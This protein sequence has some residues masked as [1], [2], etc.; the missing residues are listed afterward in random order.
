MDY[1]KTPKDYIKA[2]C[3]EGFEL[4]MNDTERDHFENKYL[5]DKDTQAYRL[6]DDSIAYA[7]ECVIAGINDKFFKDAE[8]YGKYLVDYFGNN[9]FQLPHIREERI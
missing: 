9:I 2:E 6:D 4:I 3:G 7:G 5:V 1:I 8:S